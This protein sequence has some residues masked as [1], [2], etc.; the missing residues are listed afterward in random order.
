MVN[1]KK[2]AESS[3]KNDKIRFL[4]TIDDREKALQCF[5]FFSKFNHDLKNNVEHQG[6]DLKEQIKIYLQK[7]EEVFVKYGDEEAALYYQMRE[8]EKQM[9]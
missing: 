3:N 4:F 1:H 6:F 5:I 8:L 2:E 9:E 7:E